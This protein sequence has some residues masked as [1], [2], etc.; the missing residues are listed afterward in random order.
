MAVDAQPESEAN[1]DVDVA[2]LIKQGKL[3]EASRLVFSAGAL[4]MLENGE[5]GKL[6]LP[7]IL[8]LLSL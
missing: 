1:A 7:L 5:F 2:D 8:L 4:E 3:L 6:L